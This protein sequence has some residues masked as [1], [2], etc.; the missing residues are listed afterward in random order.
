[1]RYKNKKVLAIGASGFIGTRLIE[2]LTLEEGANVI[3]MVN[4]WNKAVWVCRTTAELHQ[5]DIKEIEKNEYLFKDIDIVFHLAT[6]GGN[7]ETC[8]RI[9][10]GGTRSVI[11]MC[12]KHNIKR[13]IFL[14]SVAV[15]GPSIPEGLNESAPY[16]PEYESIYANSKIEAE[17]LF[18]SMPD[19]AELEWT[20]IRPTYVWGLNSPLFTLKQ[21]EMMRQGRF[22]TIDEGKGKFNGIYIDNLIELTLIAG[23]HPNANRQVFMI[24]DMEKK[25]WGD[26]WN[27]YAKIL[28]LSASARIFKTYS[29]SKVLKI[30]GTSRGKMFLKG[31][32]LSAKVVKKSDQLI[33]KNTNAIAGIPLKV[34]RQVFDLL[35]K[36]LLLIRP[37]NFDQWDTLK[38]S[39]PGYIDMSKS[40]NLLNYVPVKDHDQ[41]FADTKLWLEVHVLDT[42]SF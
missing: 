30:A 31:I 15:N 41:A 4:T 34:M 22:E 36:Q 1:M 9:N 35:R 28:N 8:N 42:K 13:L 38:F 19:S 12:Q 3:G 25:T 6:F 23:S 33:H 11:N 21:I 32:N 40:V 7:K 2:K 14:S 39:S 10:V 5:C 27:E 18:L 17:K 16:R 26:L 37:S 29:S 24:R 20:I